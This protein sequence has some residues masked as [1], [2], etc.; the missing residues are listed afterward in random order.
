MNQTY[1]FV[2]IQRNSA[3]YGQYQIKEVARLKEEL[4][5]YD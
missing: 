4:A 2:V 5:S 3:G 1:A